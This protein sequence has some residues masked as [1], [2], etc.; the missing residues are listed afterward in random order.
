MDL[1]RVNDQ[2]SAHLLVEAVL[3]FK[4]KRVITAPWKLQNLAEDH[5]VEDEQVGLSDL[6]GE[7]I[8]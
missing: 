7:N 5:E 8:Y 2:L 6:G 3:L 1:W 4:N